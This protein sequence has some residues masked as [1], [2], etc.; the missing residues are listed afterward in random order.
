L[1]LDETVRKVNAPRPAK[2]GRHQDD[3]IDIVNTATA[4]RSSRRKK[5]KGK[6][7]QDKSFDDAEW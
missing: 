4:P 1:D 2:R 7:S 5:T 6:E 3:V